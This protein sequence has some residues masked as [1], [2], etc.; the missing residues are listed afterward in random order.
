MNIGMIGMII[1]IGD[2]GLLCFGAGEYRL[3]SES[4]VFG[5]IK[6]TSVGSDG[7]V[8]PNFSTLT[9]FFHY[10]RTKLTIELINL[11]SNNN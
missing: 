2:D 10:F 4:A 1:S 8:S 11:L 6:C 9:H 3:H 5:K 7:L